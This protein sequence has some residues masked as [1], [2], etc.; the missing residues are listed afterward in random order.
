MKKS[1]IILFSAAFLLF[2]GKAFAENI[3]VIVNVANSQSVDMGFLK[4]IYSDNVTTW[5]NGKVIKLFDLPVKDSSRE[6]FSQKVLGVSAKESAREWSNRK[7]T[8]T[9]KNPPRTKRAKFVATAVA[10]NKLAIGYVP[11]SLVKGKQGI[12]IAFTL[13]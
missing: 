7:I 6:I 2:S 4:N 8:N 10:M 1:F 11:E 13:K 5:K 3:V 12:K 9:A